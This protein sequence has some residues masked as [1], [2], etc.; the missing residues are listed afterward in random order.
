MQSFD[1]WTGV[2]GLS[3]WFFLVGLQLQSYPLTER[4]NTFHVGTFHRDPNRKAKTRT[5]IHEMFF[6]QIWSPEKKP[7]NLS[8]EVDSQPKENMKW[9]LHPGLITP[10]KKTH[11][12]LSQFFF[13]QWSCWWKKSCN[14]WDGAKTLVDSGISTTNLNWL[15]LAGFLVAINSPSVFSGGKEGFSWEKNI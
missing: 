8:C 6:I 3:W 1:A 11:K 14:T 7:S 15:G 12:S 9:M 13:S 4:Q 10:P 2:H 5:W